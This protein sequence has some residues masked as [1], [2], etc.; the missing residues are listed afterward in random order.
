MGLRSWE[1][2]P[3]EM[4]TE[5][6]R[7]YYDLLSGKRASLIIKR[8]FDVIMALILLVILAIPMIA[9]AVWIKIDSRGTVIF[10]QER[11]TRYGK[12]FKVWKFRTMVENAE[13]LGEQVTSDQD[14]R[15]TRAG[16]RLRDHRLD[17]L[18]QLFNVLFGDMSFVG[19]RPEVPKF[20]DA[21]SPEMLATLLLPAGITSRASVLFK[22]EDEIL[23]GSD[24]VYSTYL[25]KVLPKKMEL[26][27]ESLRKFSCTDDIKTM[28]LTVKVVFIG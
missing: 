21:Y 17:E 19:T 18:P 10:K 27:L 16:A 20:V 15:I 14:A 5:E 22:D 23:K 24:D 8:I 28:F 3:D 26:N 7:P 4:R 25:E 2:L 1:K 11:V 12:K 13:K 6:L 9:L